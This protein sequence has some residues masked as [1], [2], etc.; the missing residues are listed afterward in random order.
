MVDKPSPTLDEHAKREGQV[1]DYDMVR[2][3]AVAWG[4]HAEEGVSVARTKFAP[5]SEFPEHSHEER[6]F[7]LVYEGE[8]T[9]IVEGKPHV[10]GVGESF[11]ICPGQTHSATNT[12][13]TK[14]IAITIP[15]S[16]GYPEGE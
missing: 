4:L 5:D 13:L 16:P 11:T 10:V 12:V 15:A 2:G 8:L 3:M 1:V 14:V 7:V 6:E 9:L